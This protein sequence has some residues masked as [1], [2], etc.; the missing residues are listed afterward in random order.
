MARHG[1]YG[2]SDSL[3]WTDKEGKD[4]IVRTELGFS[5]DPPEE[6]VFPQSSKAIFWKSHLTF[7]SKFLFLRFR[8]GFS[9]YANS[10]IFQANCL[11][12]KRKSRV[13]LLF[14]NLQEIGGLPK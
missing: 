2:L 11:L 9:F 13:Y 7:L 5:K 10:T 6:I 3:P 12:K 14:P 8:S 1:R 4:K